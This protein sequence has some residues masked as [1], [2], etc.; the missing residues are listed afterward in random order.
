MNVET[1]QSGG[2]VLVPSA[3][4]LSRQG[5]TFEGWNNRADGTGSAFAPGAPVVLA[6]DLTLYAI[7]LPDTYT[8]QFDSQGGSSSSEVTFVVGQS[9]LV[10]PTVAKS[11]YQFS[12]WYSSA[13]GGTLVGAGGSAITPTQSATL[14]AQWTPSVVGVTFN[15][16]GASG[17][18]SNVSGTVGE[19]IVLPGASSMIRPGFVFVGWNTSADGSGTSYAPGASYVLGTAPTLYAQ[20]R[21]VPTNILYGNVGPFATDAISISD[22][23]KRAIDRLASVVSEHDYAH[24][25]LYGF[26]STLESGVASKGLSLRRARAVATLLES[27]LRQRHD[28]K[29]RIAIA[30]EGAAPR[31]SSATLATVEV[32]LS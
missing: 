23:M 26:A 7:W 25:S 4:A 1:T 3:S 18:L 21:A 6:G 16:G 31:G 9:P 24:V 14:Y 19:S 10:L 11:G 22:A 8:I 29:V 20:W 13:N 32:F 28:V 17:S 15:L 30:G 5:Y 27:D 12:G 2:T